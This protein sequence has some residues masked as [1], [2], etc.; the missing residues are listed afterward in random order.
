MGPT[1][2][3]P[4]RRKSCYWF[5]SPLKIHSPRPS[6]NPRNLRP[7]RRSEWLLCEVPVCKICI[8]L[9]RPDLIWNSS[10]KLL[11]GDINPTT[12]I[13]SWTLNCI[14][15]MWSWTLLILDTAFRNFNTSQ[16]PIH[17]RVILSY[18]KDPGEELVKSLFTL[19]FRESIFKLWNHT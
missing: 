2:L 19:F 18:I 3:L 13:E 5:L 10:P 9:Y 7:N 4:L 17:K 16:S 14:I 6:L 12:Y 1:A 8:I 15:L 11:I